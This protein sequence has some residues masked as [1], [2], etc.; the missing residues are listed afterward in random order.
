MIEE[1][2]L[3]WKLVN[4]TIAALERLAQTQNKRKGRAPGWFAGL[5]TAPK[6][7]GRPRGSRKIQ[8]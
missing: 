6:K 8:T 2:R 7:R 4:E 5:A 3:E 1:L